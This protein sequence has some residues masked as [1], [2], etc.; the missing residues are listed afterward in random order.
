MVTTRKRTYSNWYLAKSKANSIV[1]CSQ[2]SH[3]DFSSDLHSIPSQLED[4]V[5]QVNQA[6]DADLSRCAGEALGELLG[7]V[8]QDISIEPKKFKL[9]MFLKYAAHILHETS[10]FDPLEDHVFSSFE[11]FVMNRWDPTEKM[12]II[13]T[14]NHILLCCKITTTERK[15]KNCGV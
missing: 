4:L 9:R 6:F 1:H 12:D 15:M 5:L 10:P 13:E 14:R 3:L 7:P 2:L 11:L 8:Q